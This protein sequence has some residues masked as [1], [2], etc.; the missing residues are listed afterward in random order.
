MALQ[1]FTRCIAPALYRRRSIPGMVAA[2]VA[3][4]APFVTFAIV[5]GHPFCLGFGLLMGFWM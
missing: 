4:S 5:S 1:Q 3:F 2:S